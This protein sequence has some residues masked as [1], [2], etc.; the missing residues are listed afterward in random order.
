MLSSWAIKKTQAVGQSLLTPD[1]VQKRL[2]KGLGRSPWSRPC[3]SGSPQLPRVC[4]GW[5]VQ[6]RLGRYLRSALRPHQLLRGCRTGGTLEALMQKQSSLL[7][8]HERCHRHCS[9]PAILIFVF[10]ELLESLTI[11]IDSFSYARSFAKLNIDAHLIFSTVFSGRCG[12]A[13]HFRVGETEA[14]KGLPLSVF[15]CFIDL[16]PFWKRIQKI[17]LHFLPKHIH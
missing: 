8:P 10:S 15:F 14:Q 4:A 6:P 17:D 2:G 16:L 12:L 5:H 13:F 3:R 11:I 9:L 7:P 1:L